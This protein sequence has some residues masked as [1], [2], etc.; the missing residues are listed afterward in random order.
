MLQISLQML[1]KERKKALNLGITITITLCVCIIFLQF[2]NNPI[3]NYLVNILKDTTKFYGYEAITE[4]EVMRFYDGMYKGTMVIILLVIFISLIMYSCNYYNKTNS[5][6]VGLLKIMGCRDREILFFQMIQLIVI[7]LIS[8]LIAVGISFLLIPLCQA[9]AYLY[10]GVSENIFYYALET[11]VDS[12]PLVLLLLVFMTFMQISYSIRGVIPDLLKNDEIVSFKK[13]R[14]ITIVA[15]VNYIVLFIIGTF[16]IYISD[17]NQGLIF[18][19][20][21]Y[22]IGA[23]N[24]GIMCFPNLLEKWIKLK[25]IDAKESLIFNN[26]ILNLQQ[27]KSVILMFVLSSAILLTMM[28]TNLDDLQYMIFFTLINRFRINQINKKQYYRNLSRL[29][30]NYEEIRYMTKKEKT[31]MYEM[32]AVL[33][34]VYLSNLNIAFVY[35]DK[36]GVLSALFLI[37]ELII[38]L[39]ISYRVAVYQEEMRI[40]KW[41][42]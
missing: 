13:R 14:R 3:I 6:I 1:W 36:M 35:R 11:Y 27:M 23:Y 17:L 39:F 15:N 40:R 42:K 8:Y 20:G 30:L 33:S 41:K 31:L 29:G 32:I 26:F 16:T 7:T 19:A 25:N 9:L 28:C 4:Y 34:L 5:R 18:P 37:L 22:V 21:L 12:L 2:F 24:L 10:M 38:P